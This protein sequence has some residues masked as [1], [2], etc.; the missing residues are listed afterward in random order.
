MTAA[1]R[2]I[3]PA[4]ALGAVVEIPDVTAQRETEREAK[5]TT[6]ELEATLEELRQSIAA[7]D[8]RLR[9]LEHPRDALLRSD[10]GDLA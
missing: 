6:A 1:R 9:A 4:V 7:V 10:R 5:A 8:E 2:R 3:L